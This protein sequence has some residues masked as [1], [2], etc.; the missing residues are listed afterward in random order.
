[1]RPGKL[2][3]RRSCPLVSTVRCPARPGP[4]LRLLFGL[5]AYRLIDGGVS[6]GLRNMAPV[7]PQQRPSGAGGP[8]DQGNSSPQGGVDQTCIT[9]EGNKLGQA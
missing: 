2:S 9:I 7:Q 6:R 8:Q 5:G 3:G 1:V 4:S